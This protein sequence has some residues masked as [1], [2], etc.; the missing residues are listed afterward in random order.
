[1]RRSPL[2]SRLG[3]APGRPPAHLGDGHAGSHVTAGQVGRR[4]RRDLLHLTR[5]RHLFAGETG[6]QPGGGT[7]PGLGF[8]PFAEDPDVDP[9]HAQAGHV[10]RVADERGRPLPPTDDGRSEAGL[11]PGAER[12]RGQGGADHHDRRP[13]EADPDGGDRQHR[14]QRQRPRRPGAR[15]GGQRQDDGGEIGHP[16]VTRGRSASSLDGPMP[17]TSSSSVTVL[18]RPWRV[19]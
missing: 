17:G 18:N 12:R 1:M 8:D 5:E 11:G 9:H 6:A 16:T 15:G 7:A 10:R 2:A 13:P 19:R 4:R 14:Q 3:A